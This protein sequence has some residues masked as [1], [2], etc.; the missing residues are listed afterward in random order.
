[1][2]GRGAAALRRFA[3]GPRMG[4][5]CPAADPPPAM[6]RPESA[7]A[8]APRGH[9]KPGGRRN[10]HPD[11]CDGGRRLPS[12]CVGQQAAAVSTGSMGIA[13]CTPARST[14]S[15]WRSHAP[16]S[17]ET[18][19]SVAAS[20]SWRMPATTASSC[21]VGWFDNT[22]VA[23]LCPSGERPMTPVKVPPRPT[24]N[25]Q[26]SSLSMNF[27]RSVVKAGGCPGPVRRPGVE[28]A[29]EERCSG[30]RDV[31]HDSAPQCATGGLTSVASSRSCRP[32]RNLRSG[33]RLIALRPGTSWPP[34]SPR[35]AMP[36]Q[37]A[38][39]G[40]PRAP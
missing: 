18:S 5:V 20:K 37:N 27:V 32:Q 16:A 38:R 34:T 7:G 36:V 8:G 12:P 15:R 1:M 14:S 22:L 33:R 23:R 29:P 2:T 10:V 39:P 31:P 40:C 9:I 3:T 30:I 24:R 28:P 6:P 19:V 26:R 13:R 17:C 35:I 21:S 25:C 11:R 4:R